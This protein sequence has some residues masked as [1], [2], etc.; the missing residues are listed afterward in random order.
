MNFAL[1]II[2]A[3]ILTMIAVQTIKLATDGIKG[4]LNFKNILTTYGG[5]PSSHSAFVAALTTMVAYKE[6]IDTV[7]FSIS[8]VFSLLVI[9]DAMQLRKHIDQHRQQNEIGDRRKRGVKPYDDMIH[10][11]TEESCGCTQNT[12]EDD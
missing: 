5:M 10:P 3:P 11:P 12:P 6:G 4:N 9:T 7:A 2:I 1:E 8:V